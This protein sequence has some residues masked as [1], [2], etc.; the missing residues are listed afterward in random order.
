MPRCN[1]GAVGFGG[2]SAVEHRPAQVVAQPLVVEHEVADPVRELVTLP[3]ALTSSR[4]LAFAG[5]RG[6]TRRL[7]RVGSRTGLVRSDVRDDSGLASGER[8]VPGGP[9]Q[10][11]SRRDRVTAGGAGLRHRHL[12]SHPG[13]R[14]LDRLTRPWVL[15]SRRLEEVE[16]VLSAPRRPEREEVV[17]RVGQDPTAADRDEAGVWIFGRITVRGHPAGLALHAR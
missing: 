17:I 11:A 7:D 12:A 14:V 3:A 4:S 5:G 15:G 10:A 9:N 2:Y 16:D 6:C 8:R 1:G 13:A